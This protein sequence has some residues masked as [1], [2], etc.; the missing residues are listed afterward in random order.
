M[1]CGVTIRTLVPILT[2]ASG[3]I[4]VGIV[5][6]YAGSV[7]KGFAVVFGVLVTGFAEWFAY[8]RVVSGS[9]WAALALVIVATWL[10][11]SYPFLE[12]FKIKRA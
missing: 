12:D 8:G 1:I 7:R 4:I 3:G 2:Q 9:H 6:R 11:S 10:H 5:T